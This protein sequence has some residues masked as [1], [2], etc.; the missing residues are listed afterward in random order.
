MNPLQNLKTEVKLIHAPSALVKA[1]QSGLVEVGLLRT[2]GID[3]IPGPETRRAFAKFKAAEY[4]EYPDMLGPATA[5]ALL[6]ATSTHPPVIDP[7]SPI[8]RSGIRLPEV[9]LVVANELVPGSGHFSW[10]EFTKGLSRIPES[11]AVVREIIRLAQHLDD[12][13]AFLGGRSIVITSGY[14]PP[15][16]NRV[17]G[18][19][20]NSQH[21]YGGAADIIVGGMPPHEVFR[22]LDQWHSSKGG[23]GDSQHF[24]HLDLRGYRARWNYGNA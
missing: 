14:R 24:T 3:G 9:G 13:R 8:V 11:A 22:Q 12:V 4:L 1:V 15:L 18:G 20:S 7:P 10:G 2:G 21:L 6:E 23:L 19:V 5:Q 16:V 17:V